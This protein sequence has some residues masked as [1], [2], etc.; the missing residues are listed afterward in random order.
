MPGGPA[1]IVMG[2]LAP[3]G[4]SSIQDRGRVAVILPMMVYE[5]A[6]KCIAILEEHGAEE[7][8]G[9]MVADVARCE[10]I[11]SALSKAGFDVVVDPDALAAGRR[12]IRVE[13]ALRN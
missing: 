7:R 4:Y 5:Q 1:R 9:V 8:W 12:A 13:K 3:S 10:T 11:G 6:E 2:F